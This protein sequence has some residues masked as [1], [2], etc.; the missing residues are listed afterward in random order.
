M[1]RVLFLSLSSFVALACGFAAC[2]GTQTTAMMDAGVDVYVQSKPKDAGPDVKGMYVPKGKVCVRDDEAGAPDPWK[3]P[4]DASYGGS[5]DDAGSM[6]G[7]PLEMPQ[8]GSF[9]GTVAPLPVFYPITFD[10]DDERAEIED[11]TASVGCTDWWRQSAHEYGIADAIGGAPIHLEEAAPDTITDTQ[12][13]TWLK[14]KIQTDP[15]FPK[16]NINTLYAI[17]Y[18]FET[19]IKIPSLGSSC[20]S[21]GA[22]HSSTSFMG[23]PLTYAVMPRCGSIDTLTL[24]TSHEYIEYATDP[25]PGGYSNID[26]NFWVWGVFGTTEVGDMCFYSHT[27]SLVQQNYP[28]TVQ[29]S[30]SNKS[31]FQQ[32]NPCVPYDSPDW[33]VGVPVATDAVMLKAGFQTRGIRIALND[34]R[35][36]D[37]K[38]VG[39]G[40]TMFSVDPED[41]TQWTTGKSALKFTMQTNQGKPGDVLKLQITRVGTNLTY[42]ANPFIIR[43]NDGFAD[44][45]WYGLVGD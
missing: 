28:F 3:I 7:D 26:R 30:W 2:G 17:F 40:S 10:G 14:N 43:S 37:V 19:I 29:R 35:T 25:I 32:L 13:Q 15:R 41:I 22:Y 12:I 21:F 18:P 8:I 38:M 44:H 6:T 16:P 36:I 31:A 5:P 11:F 4:A 34:T 9:K 27:S 33:F 24:A 45:F 39:T 23:A 1:K 42:G 20:M